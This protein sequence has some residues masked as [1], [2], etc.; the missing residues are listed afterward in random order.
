MQHQRCVYQVE[1]SHCLWGPVLTKLL[2]CVGT[3]T[4][5][6]CGHL[7]TLGK[8]VILWALQFFHSWSSG[9]N[10]RASSPSH[11]FQ[12]R[13]ALQFSTHGLLVTII[14]PLPPV[15]ISNKDCQVFTDCSFHWVG[16]L[17]GTMLNA[18]FWDSL[19]ALV[20]CQ[21]TPWSKIVCH[22]SV[23]NV[24]QPHH[25]CP[26]ILLTAGNFLL[27]ATRD[28]LVVLVQQPTVPFCHFWVSP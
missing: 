21:F 13:L 4:I 3:L 15:I 11:H 17:F 1:S 28:D 9:H 19:F 10:H 8:P 24:H 2:V 27:H 7:L 25:H 26:P 5:S 6:H 18:V 12:Q 20:V 22:R 14:G 23:W 16:H